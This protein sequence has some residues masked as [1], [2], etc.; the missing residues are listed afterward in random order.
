MRIFSCFLFLGAGG[1]EVRAL[2]LAGRNVLPHLVRLAQ[3]QLGVHKGRLV[4]RRGQNVAPGPHDGGVAPRLVGGARV[5]RRGDGGDEELGLS[6]SRC[7]R[8]N[9]KGLAGFVVDT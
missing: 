3:L 4:A 9:V 8:L 2:L 6:R 5:A 1:V 7:L